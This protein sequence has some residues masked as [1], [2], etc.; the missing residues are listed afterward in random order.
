[1]IAVLYE[2][3]LRIQELATL[4]WGQV[5]FN[6]YRLLINVNEKTGRL[7]HVRLL[8]AYSFHDFFSQSPVPFLRISVDKATGGPRTV[9]VLVL[10]LP[11]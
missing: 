7:R 5:K 10:P 2:S 11:V 6:E 4:S 8:T 1:L 9:A 3:G